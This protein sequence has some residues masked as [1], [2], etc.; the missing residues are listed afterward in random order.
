MYSIVFAE[1][2]HDIQWVTFSA[3]SSQGLT[4]TSW[5]LLRS[6]KVYWKF[7][8]QEHRI[9]GGYRSTKCAMLLLLQDSLPILYRLL[10]WSCKNWY[11]V[12]LL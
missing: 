9:L 1:V 7:A 3:R 4:F 8:L 10:Y 5:I 12:V 6:L 11:S 2:S